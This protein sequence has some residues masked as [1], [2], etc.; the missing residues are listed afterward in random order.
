MSNSGP[1]T[2]IASSA[3]DDVFV[4]G[5][6]LCKELIGQ[7]SFT[8]MMG[9][10]I[11]GRELEEGEVAV[12]DACLVALMEH[13]L[14]PSAL[15]TRLTYSCTPEAMQAG[16]AAGLLGIGNR[17]V[18]TVEGCG[19]L[20]A[21][22]VGAGDAAAEAKAIA[23]EHRAAKRPIPGFGHPFHK[24]N[25]PRTPAI[26]A[27]AREHGVAGPHVRALEALSRAVDA[28]L[29]RHLTINATGAVAATLGDCGVPVE[30]MRGFVLVSRC[31][32]LVA[33]IHE[34]QRDSAMTTIWH[35][36]ETAV[37]HQPHRQDTHSEDSK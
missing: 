4:R 29:G 20:L 12:V 11:L 26:L 25:D 13:G 3:S 21:R 27:V 9:L 15:A 22:I 17:F 8:E 31:A 37:P 34:E 19:A 23:S 16:V 10:A 24:P 2:R 7:R 5:R 33:H 36:A 14:T 28:E 32:G 1:V 35:A 30:I 18:G 6:S